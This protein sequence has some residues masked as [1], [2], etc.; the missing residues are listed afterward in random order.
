MSR[1][2]PIYFL[3]DTSLS[4]IGKP[5]ESVENCIGAAITNLKLNPQTLETAVINIISFGNNKIS[6]L[7]GN[8]SVTE[9]YF[10]KFS[11]SGTS[12]LNFGLQAVK[13]DYDENFIKST[14][15]KKG[16]WR[17]TLF[18]F[19]GILLN[20][21]LDN[22][23]ISFFEG[24]TFSNGTL[25]FV[26]SFIT[27]GFDETSNNKSN[28]ITIVTSESKHTKEIFEKYFSNVFSYEDTES[29]VKKF[30]EYFNWI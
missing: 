4:M 21:K 6:N 29:F 3:V 2:L 23:L 18:V 22:K 11:C 7:E 28:F 13:E 14:A 19:T 8:K 9:I 17:P 25:D 30:N 24:N 5:I 10:K 15:T 20:S 27:E 16:D 12:N 1:R 26:E